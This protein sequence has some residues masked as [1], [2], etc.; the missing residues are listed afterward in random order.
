[1][2]G[3]KKPL[4]TRLAPTPS[5]FLHK[6]NVFSFL[7]TWLIARS[8]NGQILLRIDD[9]D[10]PRVKRQYLEHIFKVID[11]LG[12]DYDAG[13]QD[14]ADQEKH[15]T[16]QSRMDLYRETILRLEELPGA[17][18]YCECSRKEIMAVAKDARYPGTCVHKGLTN[19]PGRALRLCTPTGHQEKV[20]DHIQ[21]EVTV[22][23]PT[24]MPHFIVRKKD[25]FPAYQLS[26]IIDDQF[27]GINTVVRGLDLLHST[28][29]QLYLASRLGSPFT[30]ADFY[31][32]PLLTRNNMKLSK[33]TGPVS[34][35]I[36]D[37]SERSR[38]QLLQEFASWIGLNEASPKLNDLLT[39]F[40]SDQLHEVQSSGR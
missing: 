6:G 30:T 11:W 1:M 13:P 27:F 4:K 35:S 40:N 32:H 21:G 5:G 9:L 39:G 15:F 7:L 3:D 22:S 20:T 24:H 38:E 37:F 29:A 2:D 34:E 12:I 36:G 28:A 17:T 23:L 19:V 31:H 18:F 14:V 16:Q 10:Q 26:S 33:S 25:G 8:Q